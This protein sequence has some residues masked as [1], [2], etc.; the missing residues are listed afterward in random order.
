MVWSILIVR[1]VLIQAAPEHGQDVPDLASQGRPGEECL[2]G[3]IGADGDGAKGGRED[4]HGKRG[5]VRRVRARG[6]AAQPGVPRERLVAAVGKEDARGGDKLIA[7]GEPWCRLFTFVRVETTYECNPARHL[8]KHVDREQREAA[9]HAEHLAKQRADGLPE[10]VAG[11]RVDV[12]RAEREADQVHEAE[13]DGAPAAPDHRARHVAR[14]VVRL[15]CN[16]RCDIVPR[17]RPGGREQRH[18]KRPACRPARL[19]VHHGEDVLRRVDVRG[20]LDREQDR[21]DE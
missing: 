7:G 19:V 13:D 17:Q 14:G 5:V 6:D 2:E 20:R 11:Q 8:A 16:V 10:R 18:A 15:L 3:G 1:V 4:E 21:R 9:V 12:R